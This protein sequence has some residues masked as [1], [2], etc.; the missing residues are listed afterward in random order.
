M[1]ENQ[2]QSSIL[3]YLQLLENQVKLTYLRNNS[4]AGKIKRADGSSGWINNNRRGS[5]DIIVFLVGGRALFVAV[6]NEKG[7]QSDNQK[8]YQELVEKLGFKYV[9]ARCIDDVAWSM[10]EHK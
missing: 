7:K 5:A 3:Q 6:K 9:V 2:I 4:F 10:E 1:R 8:Q